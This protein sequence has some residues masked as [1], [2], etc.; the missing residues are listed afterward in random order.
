MLITVLSTATLSRFPTGMP[1][2][3]SIF[4]AIVSALPVYTPAS[5]FFPRYHRTSLEVTDTSLPLKEDATSV[6]TPTYKS[7]FLSS[8]RFIL[9]PIS[10]LIKVIDIFGLYKYVKFKLLDRSSI[11]PLHV[12]FTQILVISLSFTTILMV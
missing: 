9:S 11:S 8:K 10:I 1:N 12:A 6:T 2:S 7:L 5:L 4:L 3:S